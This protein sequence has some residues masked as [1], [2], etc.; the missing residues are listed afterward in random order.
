GSGTIRVGGIRTDDIGSR[1]TA[2]QGHEWQRRVGG[3][4][5]EGSVVDPDVVVAGEDQSEGG[6]ARRDAATAVE[7]HRIVGAGERR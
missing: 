5:L 3:P 7:D 2:G 1:F 6:Q 4:L